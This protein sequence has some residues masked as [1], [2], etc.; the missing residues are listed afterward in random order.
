MLWEDSVGLPGFERGQ[1]TAIHRTTPDIRLVK[2]SCSVRQSAAVCGIRMGTGLG[3]TRN[4]KEDDERGSN[5]TA[6]L[7]LD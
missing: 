4:G 1:A 5:P 6:F 2:L 7:T 3:T